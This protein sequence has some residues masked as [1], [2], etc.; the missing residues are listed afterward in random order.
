MRLFQPRKQGRWSSMRSWV[1]L[2]R[3]VCS[4]LQCHSNNIPPCKFDA[5]L[6]ELETLQIQHLPCL[7]E[8]HK[9]FAQYVNK[10]HF[11]ASEKASGDPG[12]FLSI[13]TIWRCCRTQQYFMPKHSW[14]NCSLG[15]I[16]APEERDASAC[17][18]PAVQLLYIYSLVLYHYYL[19]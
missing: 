10:G 11:T 1:R 4:V 19:V 9:C 12:V 5:S 13:I 8:L 3:W 14:R 7:I 17:L 16:N 6:K 15:R 18:S 2:G